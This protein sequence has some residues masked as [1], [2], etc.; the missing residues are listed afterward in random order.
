[1]ATVTDYFE[2]TQLSIPIENI[3]II[4]I[5]KT[6]MRIVT[7]LLSGAAFVCMVALNGC[8]NASDEHDQISLDGQ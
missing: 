1:M 7:I 3:V 2:Q 6:F 8:G 5:P 4:I